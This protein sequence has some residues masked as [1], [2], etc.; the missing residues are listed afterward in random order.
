MMLSQRRVTV[1]IS[2]LVG[3]CGGLP[4][5]DEPPHPDPFAT[6][7]AMIAD[8]SRFARG[9]RVDLRTLAVD[10]MAFDST[11]LAPVTADQL[12]RRERVVRELGFP[13]GDAFL[14]SECESSGRWL[15]TQ[16]QDTLVRPTRPPLSD[17]MLERCRAYEAY[18]PFVLIQRAPERVSGGWMV[19]AQIVGSGAVE[20][21]EIDFSD[22]LVITKARLLYSGQH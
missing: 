12:I 15:I 4:I 3:A 6:V 17:E 19:T 16:G 11:E 14:A 1:L 5:V 22:D 18:R 9:L 10:A 7:V 2:F 20:V 13:P 21:W 8:S